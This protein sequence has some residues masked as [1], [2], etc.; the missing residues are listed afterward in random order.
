MDSVLGRDF[1]TPLAKEASTGRLVAYLA[2]GM[3]F[4]ENLGSSWREYVEEGLEKLN[5]NSFNPINLE[6]HACENG[7]PLQDKVSK[8]KRRGRLPEL[9][10]LVRENFFRKDMEAIKKSDFVILYYDDS[11]RKGAGSL[12][13]AWETFR[14]GKPLYVMSDI[15]LK[16]I[17]SWLIGESTQIFFTFPKLFSYLDNRQEVLKDMKEAKVTTNLFLSDIYSKGED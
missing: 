12:A 9:R 8:L 10:G 13:E 7:E 14:E 2:G 5:Y 17:P 3:E 15:P 1:Q 11:V 16:E 6:G 4:K